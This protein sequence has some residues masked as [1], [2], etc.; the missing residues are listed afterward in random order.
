VLVVI[1][2]MLLLPLASGMPA[3]AR[4]VAPQ[5][6]VEARY[7]AD[8]EPAIAFQVRAQEAHAIYKADLPWGNFYSVRLTFRDA[9]S[10]QVCPLVAQ[11]ID[12]PSDDEVVL[13]AG[14]VVTGQVALLQYCPSLLQLVARGPVTVDWVYTPVVRKG[15]GEPIHGRITVPVTNKAP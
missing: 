10:K 3:N 4:P 14:Q 13:S 12:D 1:G 7:V 2:A 8:P 11:P 15:Q 9:A 6:S 5:V